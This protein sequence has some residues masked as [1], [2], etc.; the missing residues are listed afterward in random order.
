MG[1]VS[2]RGSFWKDQVSSCERRG[3]VDR[4][5]RALLEERVPQDSRWLV[6]TAGSE[7]L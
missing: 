2:E 1:F 4:V 3:F 5:P 6:G 7:C